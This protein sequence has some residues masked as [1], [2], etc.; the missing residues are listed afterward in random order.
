MTQVLSSGLIGLI[1]LHQDLLPP[2]LGRSCHFSPRCSADASMF[3][4]GA[5]RTNN[6]RRHGYKRLQSEL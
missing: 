5:V 4:E 6:S 2:L 3:S 1:R